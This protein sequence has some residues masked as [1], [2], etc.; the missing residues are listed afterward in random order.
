MDI[1][2]YYPQ[3]VISGDKFPSITSII[4][5]VFASKPYLYNCI[6]NKIMLS[7]ELIDKFNRFDFTIHPDPL[8]VMEC[9]IDN[10]IEYVGKFQII[11]SNADLHLKIIEL[12]AASKYFLRWHFYKFLEK[13]NIQKDM[14]S[15]EYLDIIKKATQIEYC[16]LMDKSGDVI[17]YPELP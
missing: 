11:S 3:C 14:D 13:H 15:N 16:N 2:R 9:M 7:I 4:P 17:M 5:L 1:R 12:L 6:Y 10:K 8:D